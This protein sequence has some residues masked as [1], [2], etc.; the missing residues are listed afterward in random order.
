ML[1]K[2]GKG[3]N[4][5]CQVMRPVAL[6]DTLSRRRRTSSR[7]A[8]VVAARAIRASEKKKFLCDLFC[9]IVKTLAHL[10]GA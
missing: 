7:Q 2:S 3:P 5:D 10:P 4:T 9:S 6:E 1:E 8:T